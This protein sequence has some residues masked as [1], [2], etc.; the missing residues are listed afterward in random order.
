LYEKAYATIQHYQL[1]EDG[2]EMIKMEHKNTLQ[3]EYTIKVEFLYNEP[4]IQ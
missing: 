4:Q 1:T 3:M 2:G